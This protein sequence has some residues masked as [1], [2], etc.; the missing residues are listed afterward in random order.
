MGTDSREVTNRS[1]GAF[2]AGIHEAQSPVA[3]ASWAILALACAAEFMVVLDVSV[4]NVALPTIQADLGFTPTGLQWVVNGYALVFAGF[5]LL[6]GR[7]AD[8]YGIRRIFLL[9]LFLFSASSLVGGLA[10]AP[11]V[12]VA[13]RTVQGLGAAVLAPASLTLLTTTFPEGRRRIRALAI[14]TAVALAG[15]T[16]GNIIGGF[17]TEYFSW[18]WV[19]L[20]NVPI[21]AVALLLAALLLGKERSSRPRPRLDVPGATLATV[22]FVALTFGITR[23]G[24]H[25]WGDSTTVVFLA[26]GVFALTAFVWTEACFAQN[27][28]VPLRLLRAR[29]I[30]AGNAVMLLAGAAFMPMWYFLSLYMQQV[31]HYSPLQT[32]LGFLPHT[33]VTM[34][35]GMRLAPWLMKHTTDRTLIV[36]GALLA[37]V[38]F[39]WQGMVSPESAYVAGI[40][41]PGI[42]FSVGAGLLNT[43]LTNTVTSGVGRSDSGAASGIM[44]T[45]KQLGGALGLAVLVSFAG[46]PGSVPQALAV[47]YSHAFLLI[48]LI[49]VVVATVSFA[50]PVGERAE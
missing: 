21:G 50:L 15:G 24:T 13:A 33:L 36:G 19:L 4:V 42:V 35:I 2:V 44:N 9:G 22:S 3:L 23:T 16:T 12:L 5:L 10:N 7:L 17:L 8:V 38:G 28:L 14:W 32:G 46:S 47:T 41:G 49:L 31:L 34:V 25:V 26:V 48:A 11:T 1:P 29:S 40:L 20:I 37:A 45:A 18:R 39:L 27:P 6:G 43:P 30:S